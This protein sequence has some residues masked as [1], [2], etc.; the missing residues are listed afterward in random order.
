[1]AQ[2]RTQGLH[3]PVGG[4]ADKVGNQLRFDRFAQEE[5]PQD[6][7]A[8]RAAGVEEVAVSLGFAS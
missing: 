6:R 3:V 4:V 2:L 8:Q 1:M 5:P 7:S